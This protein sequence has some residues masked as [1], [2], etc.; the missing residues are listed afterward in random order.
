MIMFLC[1][2]QRIH[3]SFQGHRQG[4]E[5]RSFKDGTQHSSSPCQ[6]E[7]PWQARQVLRIHR[8]PGWYTH[9]ERGGAQL[10]PTVGQ[11]LGRYP[12]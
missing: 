1:L 5:G 4:E 2:P 6:K 7:E 10:S 9:W 8:G 3:G 12:I 11:E